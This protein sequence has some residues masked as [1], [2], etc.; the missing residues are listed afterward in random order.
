ML[1]KDIMTKDVEIVA[2]ADL[3][4]EVAKKMLQR[5]CG[6]VLVAEDDRLVGMITDRDI[7]IRCVAA[8]HDPKDTAARSIMSPQILY[9]FE[10][11]DADDVARNMGK[12]KVRRLPVLD[13]NKRL[14]GIVTL[15]DLASHSNHELCGQTLGLI[16]QQAA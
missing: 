13:I 7:A 15:G 6:A 14:V 11:D 12:N 1:I 2:P 8:E 16:C 5:D 9:C 10:T 3:L 4:G